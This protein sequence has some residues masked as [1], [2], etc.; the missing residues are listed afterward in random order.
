MIRRTKILDSHEIK[1]KINRLAWEIYEDNLS[2]E[3]IILIGETNR[4]K[5]L[6]DSLK[7]MGMKKLILDLRSNPG[8]YLHVANKIC[9]EFLKANELIV[10]TEGDKR[11]KLEY[12]ATS[13]GNLEETE[14]A[15]LINEG[16][17]SASEIVAGAIQ[18]NDR[19]II[20]GKRSFGKGLVQEQIILNDGSVIRLTTQRYFTPSGRCIQTQYRNATNNNKIDS[21]KYFTKEG[22]IVYGGGG[23]NPDLIIYDDSSENYSQIN[24]L[25]YSGII[26]DFCLDYSINLRKNKINNYTQINV[27]NLYNKF[28]LNAKKKNQNLEI[29]LGETELKFLKNLLL[30]TTARNIW[31]SNIYHQII[32]EEDKYVQKAI[33]KLSL[34][35]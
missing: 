26:N 15:V 29:N 30:A 20:I 13:T 6:K 33:T 18:D 8:G 34:I 1:L 24:Q 19:G 10:Y 31:G 35:N 23:I 25:L 4:L 11:G 12:H 27:S 9:D 21:L 28:I 3:K 22:R 17:A 14:I 2:Q 7:M 32:S 5:I 16:S